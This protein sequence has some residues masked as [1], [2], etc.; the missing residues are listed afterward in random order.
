M[1]NF[2]TPK[3]QLVFK[4]QAVLFRLIKGVIAAMF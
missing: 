4:L 2:N 3:L 1:E